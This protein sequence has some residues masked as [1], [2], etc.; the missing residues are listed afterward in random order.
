MKN[1]KWLKPAPNKF[2]RLKE[3]LAF[4]Y[5][6]YS[7][8]RM[9][10]FMCGIVMGWDDSTYDKLK[11]KHNWN[12]KDVNSLKSW[13]NNYNKALNFLYNNHK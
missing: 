9:I 7:E 3:T 12:D 8:D 5:R 6:D 10:A 4:T 13:N 2:Q 11:V 1:L